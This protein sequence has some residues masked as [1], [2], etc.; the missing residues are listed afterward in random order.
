M[1]KLMILLLVL[2]VSASCTVVVKPPVDDS[3]S[4]QRS[5]EAFKDLDTN[6]R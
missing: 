6:T 5:N 4:I 2:F 3:R 1:K